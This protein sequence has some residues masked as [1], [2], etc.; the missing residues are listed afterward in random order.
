MDITVTILRMIGSV[1]TD[2]K[3]GSVVFQVGVGSNL[4]PGFAA[5]DEFTDDGLQNGKWKVQRRIG[6]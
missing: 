2:D 6:F 4:I 5:A 3:A 1:R